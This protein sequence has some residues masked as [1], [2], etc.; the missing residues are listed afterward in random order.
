MASEACGEAHSLCCVPEVTNEV[1][2]ECGDKAPV[3]FCNVVV[4]SAC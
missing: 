3:N 1:V 4:G 2:W